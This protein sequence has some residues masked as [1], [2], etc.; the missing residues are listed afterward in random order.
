M[1]RHTLSLAALG[2]AGTFSHALANRLAEDRKSV[3]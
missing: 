1:S 2:P 3:V